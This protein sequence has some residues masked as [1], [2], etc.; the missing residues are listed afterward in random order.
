M[1]LF[2]LKIK[3]NKIEGRH[4]KFIIL[5]YCQ[6]CTKVITVTEFTSSTSPEERIACNTSW[7]LISLY[8]IV[9]VSK[10]KKKMHKSLISLH[11]SCHVVWVYSI[12]Y[13][14]LWPIF[15]IRFSCKRMHVWP[16]HLKWV[17]LFKNLCNLNQITFLI[18]ILYI[19]N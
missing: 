15:I 17:C 1:E 6:D 5:V 11:G 9:T 4:I 14:P 18:S 10:K 19:L 16:V 2:L 3:C 12:A 13:A 7:A 8:L